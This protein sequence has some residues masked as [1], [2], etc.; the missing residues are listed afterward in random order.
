MASALKYYTRIDGLRFVAIAFVL[1]DHFASYIGKHISAGYYGV[2]LFF[3][4]SGFLITNIL[5]R[6]EGTPFGKAYVK[7][8]GRRTLRIFPIYYL[9]IAVLWL[10]QLPVV[11]AHLV[12][13]LTYTYNYAWVYFHLGD[14]PI[15]HLWSLCIEE[16]YYLFWPWIVLSLRGMPRVLMA[17]TMAI[18]ALGYFQIVF[19]I[20]PSLQPYNDYGLLTRMPS[21][22][23]GSLG[24]IYLRLYALPDG[25][26]KSK[27]VELAVFA[28][29]G[30]SLMT[31][32]VTKPIL[33]AL[34]SLFLVFKASQFEFAFGFINRFLSQRRIVYLGTISYGIYVFHWP[35]GWYIS[36]YIFDPIWIQIPWSQM[37]RLG[38]LQW[39]AELIQFPLYSAIGVGVAALSFRF[40]EKPI[41][42]LKDRWFEGPSTQ[43]QLPNRTN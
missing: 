38:L 35:I 24:A 2:D 4:I 32:W 22:G 28:V 10:A 8:M 16:Q 7:F 43:E 25:F 27:W 41:L 21:L 37:G 1:I 29:L 5:L 18:I 42:S 26:F 33:L 40:L 13:V 20:F 14:G 30:I 15:N 34:A 12:A 6:T 9:L 19:N 11:H 17:I 3:V 39:H 31:D 36:K 23:M